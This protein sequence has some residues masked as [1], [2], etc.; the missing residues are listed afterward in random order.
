MLWMTTVDVV[1]VRFSLTLLG[2]V[3]ATATVLLIAVLTRPWICGTCGVGQVIR[4]TPSER[5]P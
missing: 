5:H 2:R 4:T 3:A 1:G